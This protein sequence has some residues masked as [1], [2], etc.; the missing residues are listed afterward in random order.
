M[1]GVLL[2]V[3]GGCAVPDYHLPHGFS[4]S[5]YRH[6]QRGQPLIA[7]TPT[8]SPA[9]PPNAAGLPRTYQSLDLSPPPPPPIGPAT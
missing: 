2:A 6:M 7:P 4:S 1:C 8:V 5:Y 9:V 3:M